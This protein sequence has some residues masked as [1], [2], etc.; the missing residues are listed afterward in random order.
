MPERN[1]IVAREVEQAWREGRKILLLSD[2]RAHLETLQGLLARRDRRMGKEIGFY[3]GGRTSGELRKASSCCIILATY[4]MCSEGLDIPSLNTLILATPR[5]DI[6][7]SIG[8]ILRA[9]E[10]E[11]RDLCPKIV[12]LMDVGVHAR[13]A[14]MAERRKKLYRS[15]GFNVLQYCCESEDELPRAREEDEEDEEGDEREERAQRKVGQEGK[16]EDL[17]GLLA[18]SLRYCARR[19]RTEENSQGGGEEGRAGQTRGGGVELRTG[20]GAIRPVNRGSWMQK[21]VSADSCS[22]KRGAA[23]KPRPVLTAASNS[24][25]S[26]NTRAS[27]GS[28]CNI[29]ISMMEEVDQSHFHL[30]VKSSKLKSRQENVSRGRLLLSLALSHANSKV[31]RRINLTAHKSVTPGAPRSVALP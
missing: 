13:F 11:T 27:D 6:A 26:S 1:R 5:A 31:G 14:K 21:T 18:R 28:S 4:S 7:Q 22:I 3:V 10:E 2:R 19:D 17:Q 15:S 8:R 29:F 24:L 12:D 25:V 9:Q 20:G 16:D 30:N 23:G